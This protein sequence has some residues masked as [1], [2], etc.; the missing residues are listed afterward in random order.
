MGVT[1]R[2]AGSTDRKKHVLKGENDVEQQ[3]KQQQHHHHHQHQL[4]WGL[5]TMS[6]LVT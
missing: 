2:G 1:T 4:V 6:N 3:K 5:Q